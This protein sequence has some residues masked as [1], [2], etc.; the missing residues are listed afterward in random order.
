MHSG[1][2]INGEDSGKSFQA[3]ESF[4]SNS[5]RNREPE[6]PKT[7]FTQYDARHRQYFG[8]PDEFT[9]HRYALE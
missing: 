6:M 9:N 5:L 2:T 1:G 7:V 3:P 8:L 4:A